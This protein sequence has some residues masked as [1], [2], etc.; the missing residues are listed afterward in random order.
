[1]ETSERSLAVSCF[2][3]GLSFSVFLSATEVAAAGP[4]VVGVL[5]R[6]GLGYVFVFLLAA[7]PWIEIFFVVPAAVGLG[8]NP[9]FVAVLAFLGNVFPVFVITAARGRLGDLWKRR[10]GERGSSRR[11]KRARRLFDRYG[12]PGL[13]LSAPMTTGVHLGAVVAVLLGAHNRS[14]AVWMTLGVAL[15]TVVFTVGSVVGFSFLWD[16]L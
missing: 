5:D 13:G 10:R 12:T 11:T 6:G 2:C 9:V 7:V 1:M 15:W 14:V 3:A 16:F 4:S 8:M